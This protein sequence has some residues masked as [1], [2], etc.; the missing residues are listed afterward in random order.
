MSRNSPETDTKT[1]NAESF[2]HDLRTHLSAI[3]SLTDLIQKTSDPDKSASL[4]A[5]LHFAADSA[6]AMVAGDVATN[7]TETSASI[8]LTNWLAEFKGLAE[9]LTHAQKTAF[10]LRID[11]SLQNSKLIAPDP[12]YLHRILMLL[13]D[14][15]LKYAPGSD[16]TLSASQNGQEDICLELADTGPGFQSQDP[17]LLFEPYN[18]GENIKQQGQGL[19]LWSVR[20]ILA[21]MGGSI[22]AHENK[23]NGA[24]FQIRLPAQS[25]SQNLIGGEDKK[26]ISDGLPDKAGQS[27]LHILA[28]DD[29]D[30]NRFILSEVLQAMDHSITAVRSGEEALTLLEEITPDLAIID[31]RMEEMDGW[32]LAKQ[33]KK[34]DS[35]SSM[36]LIAMSADDAPNAI[37]PFCCWMKRPVDP[38]TLYEIINRV[39]PE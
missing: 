38:G 20:N 22:T 1:Q 15:A 2:R 19:G 30:T 9:I 27:Q 37:D 28:V 8:L 10:S 12:V 26:D 17:S 13:L 4:I 36:P 25:A 31:I 39:S 3:V 11:K 16:I 23:P 7:K 33:I 6:L 5:A 18:R 32:Q 14:N 35:L 24:V 21:A 34:K 29:N